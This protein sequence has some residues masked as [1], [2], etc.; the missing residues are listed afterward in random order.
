VQTVTAF[1]AREPEACWKDFTD[2]TVLF[3]WMPGL[4]RARVIARGPDGLPLEVHFEFATSLTYSLLYSYDAAAREVRW[5][6]RAGK[7]DAV[8]GFARFEPVNDG[9]R[10][11]YGLEQG[12]G[13]SATE[14]ALDDAQRLVDAFSAW[15]QR[16]R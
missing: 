10:L 5:Q 13:R 4:R 8:S 1:V 14:R 2:P 7:R 3:A 9:T 11:T 16:R 15:M 12:E 6:P